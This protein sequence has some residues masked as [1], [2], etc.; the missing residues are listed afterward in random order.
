MT[1]AEFSPEITPDTQI[2]IQSILKGGSSY[3]KFSMA[4]VLLYLLRRFKRKLR[5]MKAAIY[6]TVRKKRRQKK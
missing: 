5:K 1:G 6:F 4:K 3:K 2:K